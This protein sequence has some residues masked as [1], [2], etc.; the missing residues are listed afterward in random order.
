MKEAIARFTHTYTL[1]EVPFIAIVT[2][3]QAE[4][5]LG[6]ARTIEF[7]NELSELV[8]CD[9]RVE[10]MALVGRQVNAVGIDY[11]C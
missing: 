4:S 7:D 11:S 2:A 5:A 10:E 1:G 3:E 8:A 6:H 9:Q